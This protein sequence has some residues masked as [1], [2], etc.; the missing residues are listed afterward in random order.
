MMLKDM[1]HEQV[2][3]MLCFDSLFN[4]QKVCLFTTIVQIPLFPCIDL[5]NPK[6]KSIEILCH[7]ASSIDKGCS[8]PGALPLSYL[9]F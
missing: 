1:K 2:G 5:G 4:R 7:G 3:H 9:T 8:K 6:I